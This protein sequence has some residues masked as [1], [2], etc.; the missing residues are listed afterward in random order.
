VAEH[1]LIQLYNEV[2]LAELPAAL[3]EEIADGLAEANAKYRR[4]GLSHDD[5]AK[6][7]VAEF[8]NA[9]AV[10]DALVRSSPARRITRWLIATGPVVGGC[11]ALTL[12]TRRAWDWPVPGVVRVLLGCILIATAIV[13]VTAAVAR[14]YRV[15]QRAGA[16]GCAGL[17]LID[18]SAITL[19]AAA[20][21]SVGWLPLLAACASSLRLAA[22]TRAVRPVL[23]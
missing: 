5:A 11:W 23:T 13:L 10:V 17:A 3:A 21:P 15:A 19:V 18:A 20:A 8:G 16:A 22:V 12:I 1:R 14:R 4:Q 7:A 6:A 9:R 2:L